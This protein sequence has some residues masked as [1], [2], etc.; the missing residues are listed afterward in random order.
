MLHRHDLLFDAFSTVPAL[1][2]E[3]SQLSEMDPIYSRDSIRLSHL[4]PLKP[5]RSFLPL[6]NSTPLSNVTQHQ[7]GPSPDYCLRQSSLPLLGPP[8]P[9]STFFWLS[10]AKL[11]KPTSLSLDG[12]HFPSFPWLQPHCIEEVQLLHRHKTLKRLSSLV[13]LLFPRTGM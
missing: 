13:C 12:W 2:D 8:K 6:S 4:A 1:F 9:N 10:S 11:V 5:S 7:K 3:T